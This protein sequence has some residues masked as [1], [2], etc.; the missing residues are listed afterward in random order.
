MLI[1][2]KSGCVNTRSPPMDPTAF[3]ESNTEKAAA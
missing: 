2:E 1:L 3:S